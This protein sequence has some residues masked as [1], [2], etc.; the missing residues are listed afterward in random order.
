MSHKVPFALSRLVRYG[1]SRIPWLSLAISHT[2]KVNEIIPKNMGPRMNIRFQPKLRLIT[3]ISLSIILTACGGGSDESQKPPTVV[4]PGNGNNNEDEVLSGKLIDSPIAGFNYETDSQ[5][6]ITGTDGVF[7]YKGGETISFSIGDYPV[8]IDI[9]PGQLLTPYELM[10]QRLYVSNFRVINFTR[11][12]QTID[13]DRNPDNGIEIDHELVGGALEAF[14][15]ENDEIEDAL[16]LFNKFE[17]VEGV[18]EKIN[19][20]DD[21]VDDLKIVSVEDALNHL[22]ESL[23]KYSQLLGLGSPVPVLGSSDGSGLHTS[24]E[25]DNASLAIQWFSPSLTDYYNAEVFYD[26]SDHG[27]STLSNDLNDVF[28]RL[29]D[30]LTDS[31]KLKIALHGL[32]IANSAILTE[33]SELASNNLGLGFELKHF[34]EGDRQDSIKVL[35]DSEFS[36][37]SGG[38]S[39]FLND[40][41][42]WYEIESLSP[43][44]N[45]VDAFEIGLPFEVLN[46]STADILDVSK[47]SIVFFYYDLDSFDVVHAK[48]EVTFTYQAPILLDYSNGL[49]YELT[50][51]HNDE[52]IYQDYEG[53]I[54]FNNFSDTSYAEGLK[55]VAWA[56]EYKSKTKEPAGYVNDYSHSSYK[57]TSSIGDSE[58]YS[59]V[60]EE[61]VVVSSSQAQLTHQDLAQIFANKHQY[62][63][64]E[65]GRFSIANPIGHGYINISKIIANG[66]VLNTTSRDDGTLVVNGRSQ[67][68][69]LS[70]LGNRICSNSGEITSYHVLQPTDEVTFELEISPSNSSD[71]NDSGGS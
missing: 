64:F 6:G 23:R 61:I 14:H 45:G 15:Q 38:W 7:Q 8:A 35:W 69:F 2:T 65:D 53:K 52:V 51:R 71:T 54:T 55:K 26:Y 49:D 68:Q 10:H 34:G 17:Y 24:F 27:F 42:Q 63:H 46:I 36:L 62:S 1:D 57:T 11:F 16:D 48:P 13:K 59:A 12:L 67:C 40:E 60:G 5:S 39:I 30:A 50:L 19:E 33:N 32:D 20:I 21:S 28:I 22:N 56:I 44:T 47:A 43:Q 58:G 3:L 18:I 66:G 25:S 31:P 41:L 37:T 9:Q 4:Q 70:G 29:D